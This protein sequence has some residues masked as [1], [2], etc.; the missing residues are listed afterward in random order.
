MPP[1]KNLT[2]ALKRDVLGALVAHTVVDQWF[3]LSEAL[4]GV[5]EREAWRTLVAKVLRGGSEISGGAKKWQAGEAR[6]IY[7][8]SEERKSGR[9]GGERYWY[10]VSSTGGDPPMQVVLRCRAHGGMP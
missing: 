3:P 2:E 8:T 10:Y 1:N 9:G 4:G 5:G 7:R 6:A